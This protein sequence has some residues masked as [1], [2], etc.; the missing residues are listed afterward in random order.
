MAVAMREAT[1]SDLPRILAIYRDSGL[2]AHRSLDPPEAR[3]RFRKMSSYPW[4]RLFVA[5]S[6]DGIVGTFALLIMDNLANGGAPSGVVED[7]AVARAAQG[8]G[9]GRAMMELALD[10]CR[11]HGCYKMLLSS[12]AMRTA[13]HGFY[14]ALGFTKHGYSFRVELE[15]AA[16]AGEARR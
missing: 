2:D 12:N 7:V 9:I 11:R 13:A 10:E 14:E 5:E 3:R 1:E 8:R 4:Y 6:D 16:E 15:D